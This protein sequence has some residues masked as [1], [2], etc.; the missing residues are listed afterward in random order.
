MDP[1]DQRKLNDLYGCQET[2][3]DI[4]HMFVDKSHILVNEVISAIQTKNNDSL[5]KICHKGIGQARYIASPVLEDT[6]VQIQN[7]PF[8]EKMVLVKRLEAIIN[9]ICKEYA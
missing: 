1:I 5:A 2:A 3:N 9:A 4:L 7:A 6:L 8:A